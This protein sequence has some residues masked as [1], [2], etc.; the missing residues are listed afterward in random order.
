MKRNSVLDLHPQQTEVKI[1]G[2][3]V[4]IFLVIIKHYQGA[5]NLQPLT[6]LK[7]LK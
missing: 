7:L 2:I 3:K 4:S 6:V 5:Q 1:T